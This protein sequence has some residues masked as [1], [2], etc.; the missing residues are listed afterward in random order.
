MIKIDKRVEPDAWTQKKATPGFTLY[1]P[2]SELRDALLA[3][4][5]N[6]CAYCMREIPVKDKGV[7]ETSKIEHMKSRTD[8]PDLQLDYN[9]MVICCPGYINAEEHCDKSK[10]GDSV[11]F[12]IFNDTFPDTLS[13]STL[14]GNIKSSNKVWNK[15]MKDILNLNNSMLAANR[16]KTLDGVHQVLEKKKWRKAKLHEKLE[17]WSNSDANG[18]RKPYCGIVIWYLQKK[19]R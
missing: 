5:G 8:R 10:N 11:T 16:L 15:E 2:I 9:N 12:S 6:I 18:K 14:N 13:Y 1:E 4:Q 17:E 7:S 3:E 19:L